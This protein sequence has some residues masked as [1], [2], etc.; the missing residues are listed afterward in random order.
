MGLYLN[1]NV[2]LKLNF[3]SIVTHKMNYHI[4]NCLNY[5]IIKPLLNDHQ[6]TSQKNPF[7]VSCKVHLYFVEHYTLVRGSTTDLYT[8]WYGI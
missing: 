7:N 2:R 8:L 6:V 5:F 4:I 1:E 3:V